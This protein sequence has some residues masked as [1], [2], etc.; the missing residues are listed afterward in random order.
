MKKY[1]KSFLVTGGTGFIGAGITKLLIKKNFKVKIFDNNSR[2][3][4]NKFKLER[5]R[6]KFIKG[7]IRNRKQVLR[8]CKNVDAVVHLAY[9][10]GTK[11]FYKEPVKILEIAVKGILNVI[12]S[13]I[14]NNIKE[15]YLASSSEVYQTPDK[16]PTDE[17]EMLKIPDIHNPRYSYG[18]GKILT[19]LMGINYGKKYFKKLIIFRPHNVYGSDMGNEHV[20]PEF[21]NRFKNLKGKKFKIQGNGDETRSFI[22]IDDFVKGFECILKKGKH[23][24]IYNIGTDELVSIKQLAFKLA[25]I[26][27]KKI[28]LKKTK[29]ARGGTKK[30][31][32]SIRKIKKIG[33]KQ[34]VKL[35]DGLKSL[36]QQKL[37]D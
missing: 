22:F 25:K 36:V 13:C 23:L 30:R 12:E 6:F 29:L 16:I 33:F 3:H 27:K 11:Y 8:A 1:N 35:E 10:N 37:Y 14:E 4:L 15:L 18:G 26:F 24:E 5:K 34:N 28:V 31:L 32:P 7:D 9:V 17:Y 20:I 21:I 19:E 2:G